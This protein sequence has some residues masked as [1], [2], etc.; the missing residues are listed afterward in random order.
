MYSSIIMSQIGK[1]KK[2]LFDYF[3]ANNYDT[4]KVHEFYAQCED[5]I[6]KIDS[7]LQDI[8][9]NATYDC[10]DNSWSYGSYSTN[11]WVDKQESN[12]EGLRE[13]RDNAEECYSMLDDYLAE[14]Q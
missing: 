4:D 5:M 6:A 14:L 3:V 2:E 12:L 9:A 7:E 13:L 10:S 11:S 1:S 8:Y